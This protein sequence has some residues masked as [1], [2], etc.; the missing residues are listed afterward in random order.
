MKQIIFALILA[1]SF[2]FSVFAQNEN[3][4]CPKIEV[5]GGGQ[6]R[7]GE[8]MSFTANVTGGLRKAPLEYE[9]TVSGGTISS[10]QGTS[11]ITVDISGT[12]GEIN[13][14]AV[15]KIKGL[16][17]NCPNT[18]SESG[19]IPL[20]VGFLTIS[21]EFGNLPRNEVRVRIDMLFLQLKNEMNGQLYIINYGTEKEIA[22]REKLI[23]D[24]IAFRK[25]DSYR[26]TMVRGGENPSRENGIWSRFYIV[27]PGMEVPE[28]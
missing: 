20:C 4:S 3:Q 23:R 18:A 19:S 25:Y 27:P 1:F 15:V 11:S 10:G 9:W 26:V 21:D 8:T 22:A 28:P 14:T 17:D 5:T 2:W 16:F 12:S 24:H 6:V 7:P 13:V